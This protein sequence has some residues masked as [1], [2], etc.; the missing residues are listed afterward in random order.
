VPPAVEAAIA[1]VR[2]DYAPDRR[3]RINSVDPSQPDYDASNHN[4]YL[5]S[6]RV[7]G[8]SNGVKLLTDDALLRF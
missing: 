7:L 1:A 3:V 4:R 2:R 8:S 5:R 6:K